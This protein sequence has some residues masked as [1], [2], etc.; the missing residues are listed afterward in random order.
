MAK[1]IRADLLAARDAPSRAD[2]PASEIARHLHVLRGFGPEPST[3]HPVVTGIIH[4]PDGALEG[5][6]PRRAAVRLL[7][8]GQ[9][10]PGG[11]AGRNQLPVT[12]MRVGEPMSSVVTAVT[13]EPSRSAG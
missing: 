6:P 4:G 12:T 11:H 8:T 7:V 13:P 5:G 2:V 3:P 9:R 10:R 1:D